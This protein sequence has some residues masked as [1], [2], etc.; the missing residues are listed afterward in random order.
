MGKLAAIGACIGLTV[1]VIILMLVQS[2]VALAMAAIGQHRHTVRVRAGEHRGDHPVAH[3]PGP[4]TIVPDTDR[5]GGRFAYRY[6]S[7]RLGHRT[8]AAASSVS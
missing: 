2:R 3:A 6:R 4:A 1:I 5:T 7:S 8:K